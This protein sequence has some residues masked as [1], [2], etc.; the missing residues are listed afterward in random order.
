M[1][2]SRNAWLFIGMILFVAA[3]IVIFMFYRGQ[4]DKRK[5]ARDELEVAGNSLTIL[6]GQRAALE[7]ELAK[8]EEELAQWNDTIAQ[9]E[10]RLAQ[11]LVELGETQTEFPTSLE[12]IE[13]DEVLFG[14]ANDSNI[15]LVILT[16][17]KMDDASVDDLNFK[18]ASFKLDVQGEVADILDFID[19]VVTNNDFKTAILGPV[20]ITVPEPV[21]DEQKEAMREGKRA[22]LLAE[23]LAGIT[24]EEI[25][26]L[27]LETIVEMTGQEEKEVLLVREMAETIRIKIAIALEEDYVNLLSGDLA[28]LIELHISQSIVSEL[29][30]P[31]AEQI[32]DLIDGLGGEGYDQE[33]LEELLGPDLAELL[34][35]DIAGSLQGDI[36]TLLDKYVADVVGNKMLDLASS[37]LDQEVVDEYVVQQVEAMEL[38]SAS[39]QLVIYTYLVEGE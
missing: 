26:Q 29:L 15:N 36:L 19:N 5:E 16:A 3:A 14:F 4:V 25:T 35:E 20:M 9:L 38:P 6:F 17:S 13:Y 8:N 12:S 2:L 1:R 31:L 22:E 7:E 18:T 23:E 33:A 30:T 37:Q 11:A 34:G 27:M 21:T 39:I 10:E 24:T 28:E 32:A